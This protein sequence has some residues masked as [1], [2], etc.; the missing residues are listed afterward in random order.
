MNANI[1]SLWHRH[2]IAHKIWNN[3]WKSCRMKQTP[4]SGRIDVMMWSSSDIYTITLLGFCCRCVE[5]ASGS[6]YKSVSLQVS[7]EHKQHTP[8]HIHKHCKFKSLSICT[9]A[10]ASTS[11]CAPTK[12]NAHGLTFLLLVPLQYGA[13]SSGRFLCLLISTLS[14][15]QHPAGKQPPPYAHTHKHWQR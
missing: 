8:M 12:T 15:W 6:F 9:V 1:F 7:E 5:M 4:N 10:W 2:H 14:P 13:I 3:S 11:G